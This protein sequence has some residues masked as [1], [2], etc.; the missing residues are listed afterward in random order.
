MDIMV[1]R[2]GAS[3]DPAN[4]VRAMVGVSF[5]LVSQSAGMAL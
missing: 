1:T 2:R 4:P 5:G 3:Y